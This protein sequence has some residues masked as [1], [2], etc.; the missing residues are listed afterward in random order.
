[1]ETT[2]ETVKKFLEECLQS[3][4]AAGMTFEE[5]RGMSPG[6]YDD[7]KSEVFELLRTRRLQQRFDGG[8]RIMLL[9]LA[10]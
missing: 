2:A 1:M 3:W 6:T 5:L 8:N 10:A 4:P 9:V 7:V